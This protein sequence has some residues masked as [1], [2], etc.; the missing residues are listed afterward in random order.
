MSPDQLNKKYEEW[1]NPSEEQQQEE[2]DE[3]FLSVARQSKLD[4]VLGILQKGNW[5]KPATFENITS[6]L[7]TV[8]GKDISKLDEGDK[9]L[10]DKMWGLAERGRGDRMKILPAN[11]AGFFSEEN[12]LAGSSKDISNAL[13]GNEDQEDNI[14]KG[15][16]NYSSSRSFCAII[17]FLR[18]Y[19]D[20]IIRQV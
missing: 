5:K 6:L 11:L 12:L 17:P 14:N 9:P 16:S 3:A 4:E 7:N 18:K 15:N 8:F 2:G 1:A 10:C 13:F 19:T 20:K